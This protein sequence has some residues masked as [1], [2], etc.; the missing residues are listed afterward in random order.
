MKCKGITKKNQPCHYRALNDGEYCK[1]HSK[2]VVVPIPVIE[3]PLVVE[4]PKVSF[5]KM[6]DDKYLHN[7]FGLDD[8]FLDVEHI[9]KF[10]EEY[11]N[12]ITLCNYLKEQLNTSLMECPY[13]Q[14]PS[15]P[16]TKKPYSIN[17]IQE[18]YEY[19]LK[20]SM[21]IDVVLLLFFKLSTNSLKKIYDY[22][23]DEN[24][25]CQSKLTKY[26]GETLRYQLIPVKNS[27]NLFTGQWCSKKTETTAF[28][29]L[30]SYYK[31]LSP[32]SINID[33]IVENRNKII[34]GKILDKF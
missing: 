34:I 22:A 16:F 4:N 33:T 9:V 30:L 19:V 1:T 14:Y 29:D 6:L 25:K 12:V 15:N 17:A 18:L 13:P 24:T 31:Q 23:C 26:F 32:Y 5:C 8:S 2:A 3:N 7:L 28:E 10:D 27:Q 20:E 11:Y 21:N